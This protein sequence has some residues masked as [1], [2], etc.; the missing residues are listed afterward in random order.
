MHTFHHSDKFFQSDLFQ[1]EDRRTLPAPPLHSTGICWAEV[2]RFPGDRLR[3]LCRRWSHMH[4][5]CC[6]MKDMCHK[7]QYRCGCG[8]HSCFGMSCLGLCT[9]TYLS[10]WVLCY[11][12]HLKVFVKF[13]ELFNPII[14]EYHMCRL[15]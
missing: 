12:P 9:N 15:V 1:L 4:S 7:G 10:H 3:V 6:S 11:I 2:D 13:C 8:T 5:W 14:L